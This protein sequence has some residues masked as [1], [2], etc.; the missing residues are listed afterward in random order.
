[1]L[2][3]AASFIVCTNHDLAEE[4]TI[5]TAVAA[6]T[7]KEHIPELAVLAGMREILEESISRKQSME[8]KWP[9]ARTRYLKHNPGSKDAE[10]AVMLRT[11]EE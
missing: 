6:G 2:L 4:D 9:R 5:N 10:V 11:V 8:R 1:V 3:S 7:E